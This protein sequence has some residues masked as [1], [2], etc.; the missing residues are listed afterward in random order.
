MQK[1]HKTSGR[2]TLSPSLYRTAVRNT[3][4][5]RQQSDPSRLDGTA[6][7]QAPACSANSRVSRWC[8]TG[9]GTGNKTSPCPLRERRSFESPCEGQP[10]TAEPKTHRR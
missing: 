8:S 5:D 7:T 4:G 1:E 10:V 9:E 6:V 2:T 3:G